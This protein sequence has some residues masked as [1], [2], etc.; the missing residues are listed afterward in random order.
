MILLSSISVEG[1]VT[2]SLVPSLEIEIDS[3]KENL[4]KSR[5]MIIP[6]AK[7]Q[8]PAVELTDNLLN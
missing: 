6:V 5:F 1:G 4:W 7:L 2:H 3:H 8:V